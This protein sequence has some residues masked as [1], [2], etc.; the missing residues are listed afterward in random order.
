MAK[1]N[2]EKPASQVDLEERQKKDYMPPAQLRPGVDPEPSHTGFVGVDPIY[3]N[4]ANATEAPLR[5]EK[6]PEKQIEETAYAKDADFEAGKTPEG[7]AAAAEDDEE[8]EEPVVTTPTTNS[9]ASSSTP[10]PVPPS[11]K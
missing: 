8:D 2:Y 11:N 1:P 3:Q 10:P 9:P 7:Q 5:A 6:G 4:Y